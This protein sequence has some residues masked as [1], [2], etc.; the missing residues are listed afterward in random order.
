MQYFFFIF[1]MQDMPNST[2]KHMNVD[3]EDI[4]D[5]DERTNDIGKRDF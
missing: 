1:Q 3:L 4:L 5:P 2:S